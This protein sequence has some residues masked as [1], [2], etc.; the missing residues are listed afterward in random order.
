MKKYSL[1]L[2][3]LILVSCTTGKHLS[4]TESLIQANPDSARIVLC[5]WD[6]SSLVSQRQKALH[7][8]L[9]SMSL[10]KCYIDVADDSLTSI[11]LNYFRDSHDKDHRMKA[12]YYDGLVQK[13]RGNILSALMHLEKARQEARK[14][15]DQHYL[16]L[17]ARNLCMLHYDEWDFSESTR[18]AEE[19]VKAFSAAGE[20][21]Y[22]LYGLS[23]LAVCFKNERRFRESDSLFRLILR[24]PD[25]DDH[26]RADAYLSLAELKLEQTPSDP[27]AALEAMRQYQS[28]MDS[29]SNEPATIMARIF[30]GLGQMDS[31]KYYLDYARKDLGS[32]IDSTRYCYGSYQYFSARKDFE[33]ADSY[34]RQ[35]YVL[36]DSITAVRLRRSVMHAQKEWFERDAAYQHEVARNRLIILLLLG[37]LVVLSCL[38][39]FSYAKRKR[40]E[41]DRELDRFRVAENEL[42]EQISLL[43]ENNEKQRVG[44]VTM[45]V[46]RISVITMLGRQFSA[47]QDTPSHES[48]YDHY[49]K[50]KKVV[51]DC[52]REISALRGDMTFLI[53]LEKAVDESNDRVIARLR[54]LFK[55]KMTEQDY[56]IITLLVAGTPVKGISLVTGLESGTI[57]T[58]KTRY[59]ER[60]LKT[61]TPD[62][63]FFIEKI[64]HRPITPPSI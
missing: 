5:N 13:N 8:L 22:E 1:M 42:T 36:E 41:F 12:Y 6:R 57:S 63:D 20:R 43:T 33:K 21:L 28:I 37:C 2:L 59:K 62:A 48:W 26:L 19:S 9:L 46:G 60:I 38:F 32:T 16:G 47:L 4:E 40:K 23:S 15:N 24:Q 55:N 11:A 53:G 29:M 61:G 27:Q 35:C 51:N 52:K 31:S 50:M 30:T 25:V 45:I 17:S 64:Y 58:R 7:A 54:A 49:D 18:C 39:A 56:R 34:L 3:L 10:D 44:L 14:L